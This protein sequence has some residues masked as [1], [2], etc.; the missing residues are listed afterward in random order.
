MD[1]RPVNVHLLRSIECSHDDPEWRRTVSN[2]VI[3]RSSDPGL[4]PAYE[5]ARLV[6]VCSACGWPV[7]VRDVERDLLG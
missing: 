7:E 4:G 1:T 6:I 3:Y 2:C 5:V